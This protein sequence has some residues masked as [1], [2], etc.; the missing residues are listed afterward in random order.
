[1]PLGSAC[2]HDSWH[3]GC[4]PL[5]GPALGLLFQGARPALED[6]VDEYCCV[7]FEGSGTQ[8]ALEVFCME[9][10]AVAPTGRA[11]E[12][13]FTANRTYAFVSCYEALS[14][15]EDLAV[16]DAALAD[17]RRPKADCAL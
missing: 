8:C 10:D 11:I 5:A 4:L 14:A 13:W 9:P 17:S 6:S 2:R 15:D 12:D 1:V 16:I 7:V 3:T